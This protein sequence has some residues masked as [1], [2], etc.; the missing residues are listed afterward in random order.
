PIR[1]SRP[2]GRAADRKAL[3]G[4]ARSGTRPTAGRRRSDRREELR[5][6]PLS[7]N[8]THASQVE[9]ARRADVGEYPGLLLA[10]G[11]QVDLAGC[12]A[13]CLETAGAARLGRNRGDPGRLRGPPP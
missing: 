13:G 9:D 5:G 12:E 11:G 1:R 8:G 6:T 4:R 10:D 7:L 2:P 3:P